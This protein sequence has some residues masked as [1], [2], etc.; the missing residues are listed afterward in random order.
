[1]VKR[2]DLYWS[3]VDTKAVEE[4]KKKYYAGEIKTFELKGNLKDLIINN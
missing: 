1:M 3:E 2:E 4:Y